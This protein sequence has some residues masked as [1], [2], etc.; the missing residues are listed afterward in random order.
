[1]RPEKRLEQLYILFILKVVY[2]PGRRV[3]A[4]A[5]LLLDPPLTDPRVNLDQLA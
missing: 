5:N 1:M 2:K 3:A 4:A